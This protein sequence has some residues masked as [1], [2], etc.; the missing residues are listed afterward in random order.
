M[1]DL[2]K[3]NL[4]SERRTTAAP[5]TNN[6]KASSALNGHYDHQE[7]LDYVQ[8]DPAFNLGDEDDDDALVAEAREGGPAPDQELDEVPD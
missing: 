3:K 4:S 1:M 2:V 5:S 6:H 7:Q 8:E